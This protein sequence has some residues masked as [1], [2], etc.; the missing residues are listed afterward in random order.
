MSTNENMKKSLRERA[1]E[2]DVQLPLM[3]DREKGDSKELLG[4]DSTIIDYGFLPNEAGEVYAVIVVKERPKKFYFGGTVITDRLLKL[5]Q[6]GYRAEI[7]AEGLPVRMNEK[8][9]KNNRTFVNV[10]FY[11]ED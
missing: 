9:S 2:F 6:D 3:K 7:L 1:K 5:D 4:Q 8:K 10:V 11:P